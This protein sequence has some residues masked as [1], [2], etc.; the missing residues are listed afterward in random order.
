MPWAPWY[1]WRTPYVQYVV[2]Y[3][4]FSHMVAIFDVHCSWETAP[5]R[6]K[7]RWEQKQTQLFL[8]QNHLKTLRLLFEM[9]DKLQ[10]KLS[11]KDHSRSCGSTIK[12]RNYGVEPS[13]QLISLLSPLKAWLTVYLIDCQ[14][15]HG[16]Y[17]EGNVHLLYAW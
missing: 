2:Y 6:Q 16:S 4:C 11:A 10:C 17:T 1:A 8:G 12:R 9:S 7:G 14:N 15:V 3:I 13:C 5:T